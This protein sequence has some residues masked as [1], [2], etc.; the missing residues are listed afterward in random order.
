MATQKKKKEKRKNKETNI[1][2]IHVSIKG[3]HKVKGESSS[4]REAEETGIWTMYLTPHR[5]ALGTTMNKRQ[6]SRKKNKPE[7]G[8]P[9]ELH[10]AT[11]PNRE[12]EQNTVDCPAMR[13]GRGGGPGNDEELCTC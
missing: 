5:H 3:Q 13:G 8:R 7:R 11:H 4:I 6:E 2:K 1:I 12:R 10:R 9:T